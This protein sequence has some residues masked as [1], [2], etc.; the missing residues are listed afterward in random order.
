M[1]ASLTDTHAHLADPVL[2]PNVVDVVDRAARSNVDHILAVGVDIQSSA[3]SVALSER[4]PTVWA[5]VGVHPH[6]VSSYN[7]GT[8]DELRRLAEHPKVVAVG[9]IGLDYYRNVSPVDLQQAVFTEQLALAASL[10]LPVVVHNR[11]A[12]ADVLRLI[13]SVRRDVDLNTR[14]GV[15]HCFTSD[16]AMAEHAISQGFFISFA[17][18]LTFRRANSLRDI[19]AALPGEWILAETDSPYLAPVPL[20]GQI[21]QPLNVRLVVGQLAEVR[22]VSPDTAATLTSTN[23]RRLFRW[24]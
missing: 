14:A 19:A 12:S 13:G 10:D 16:E 1:P 17:G 11:E 5:A 20:R 6:E 21:N 3:E 2:S 4:F 8:L 15:L 9:E 24:A 23:A 7:S 22:G 18:N